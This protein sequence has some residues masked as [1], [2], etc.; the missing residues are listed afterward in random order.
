MALSRPI[1]GEKVAEIF[2]FR[3]LENVS[4]DSGGISF[5]QFLTFKARKIQ[6]IGVI[7]QL[8]GQTHLNDF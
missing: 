4:G 2:D 1:K 5:L 7:F 8:A 6:E 3:A